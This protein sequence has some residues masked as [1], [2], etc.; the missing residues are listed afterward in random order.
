MADTFFFSL[1]FT[2]KENFENRCNNLFDFNKIC[3]LQ[4]YE[5]FNDAQKAINEFFGYKLENI[6]EETNNLNRKYT[7]LGI[8]NVY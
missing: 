6:F 1:A 4:H 7:E 5:T 3:K 2:T 8:H